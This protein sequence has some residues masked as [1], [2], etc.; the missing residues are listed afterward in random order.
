MEEFCSRTPHI[1]R[2]YQ[3]KL[4]MNIRR[5]ISTT[6]LTTALCL[7]A[8]PAFPQ[9]YKAAPVTVSKEK[10][11]V[12]GRL[13]YSHVVLEKQTLY[14][15]SKAYG[16]SIEEIEAANPSL[17][18]DGLRKNSIIIIPLENG[19]G[20]KEAGQKEDR[21]D[22]DNGRKEKDERK[23]REDRKAS[24]KEEGRKTHTVRWFE[25][26]E[27]I[28]AQYGISP[29]ALIAANRLGDR[30]PKAREI[31]VIPSASETFAENTSAQPSAVNP[32]GEAKSGELR[33]E[34]DNGVKTGQDSPEEEN[35][36]IFFPKDNVK[37]A[38]V[39]PFKSAGRNPSSTA[40][41]FYSGVLLAARQLGS[42]GINIDLK[43]Y[44]YAEGVKARDLDG[45]DFIVGPVAADH[46]A[47]ICKTAAPGTM[48]ISPLDPKAAAVA[49]S[50]DNL[51]Q[52]PAPHQ[53][54]YED[55]VKWIG[56][57]EENDRIIL[58][59]EKDG[60]KEPDMTELRNILA[61]SG[62]KYESITYSILEG[63]DII[64]SFKQ[65]STEDGTNKF[66]IASEREGFVTDVM[67][68][69]TILAH[70]NR[71]VSI[72]CHSKVR[73]FDIESGYMHDN[74]LHVSLSYWIDYDNPQVIR[75]VKEYRALMNTEPSQFSFQG[76]DITC[77]FARLCS[78]Y[79]RNWQAKLPEVKGTMLQTRFD[80]TPGSRI[81][82]GVRRLTYLPA[83]KIEEVTP[84]QQ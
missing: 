19:A 75:F 69:I 47:E 5:I 57:G 33:N 14:S 54:Q 52:V 67:R 72:Y 20:R 65:K 28:A 59:Y 73:N 17:K 53:T 79:G 24:L 32:A 15:I 71:K 13:Y 27:S 43:V 76:Y 60:K 81:N 9:D 46:L 77:W 48:V 4:S 25:T 68:N 11:K 63:R 10:V 78:A 74:N 38:L 18:T 35:R 58:V 42:E 56:E 66:L 16:V 1:H 82:H 37:M 70:D 8:A 61:A 49:D 80:F 44:D 36:M 45:C 21:K 2:I 83:F 34:C 62:L 7:A 29:E 23:D 3:E 64:E 50:L 41:D 31:L 40:L 12:N 26:V 55:L 84:E 6:V 39:M 51:I 22:K 30:Q